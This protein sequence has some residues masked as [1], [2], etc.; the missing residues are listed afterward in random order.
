MSSLS[1][2]YSHYLTGP[3]IAFGLIF[4]YDYL[5]KK[6]FNNKEMMYD[7]AIMAGSYLTTILTKNLLIDR[8]IVINNDS[9]QGN[10]LN[11]CLNAF[12]YNYAYIYFMSNNKFANSMDLNSQMESI[13]L[14]ALTFVVVSYLENPLINFLTSTF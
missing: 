4:G 11:V 8:L 9:V 12:I 3:A 13:L 6:G 7:G 14:G 10:I 2:S 1:L 5:N